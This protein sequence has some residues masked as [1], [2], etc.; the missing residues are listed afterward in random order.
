MVI[1]TAFV[2]P[3]TIVGIMKEVIR[4]KS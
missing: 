3:D 4:R 2:K 1:N